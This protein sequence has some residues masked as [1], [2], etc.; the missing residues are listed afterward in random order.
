M[1]TYPKEV[2]VGLFL[3][4]PDSRNVKITYV[5]KKQEMTVERADVPELIEVLQKAYGL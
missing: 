4:K 1:N 3:I 5:I 2:K